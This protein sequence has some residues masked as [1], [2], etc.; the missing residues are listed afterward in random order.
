MLV[1]AACATAPQSDLSLPSPDE[2]SETAVPDDPAAAEETPTR[3]TPGA[4][5]HDPS[6]DPVVPA[7]P[8]VPVDDQPSRT[9]PH[10]IA[11]ADRPS[12]EV[13]AEPAGDGDPIHRFA[14]PREVGAPLTFLID[15]AQGEWLRV[16]LP[17]RPNGSTGWIHRDAVRVMTT[18]YHLEVSLSERRLLLHDGP[19]VVIDTPIGVGGDGTPTPPG[20]YYIT[21]LLQP[22]DPDGPYGPFAFGLSGFSE[23]HVD[24]A[25]GEGVIG[26]HGTNDPTSI[27][28]DVSNGCIRLPNDVIEALAGYLPL[29]TPVTITA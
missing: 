26:I 17:V 3:P 8:P 19:E 10:L 2:A 13:Y 20:R 14:H 27:G 1:L 23:V 4:S 16:L 25:G 24:F 9:G 18:S 15:D 6:T 21:E 11:E 22:P 29:G 7:E 5:E 12:I 28:R